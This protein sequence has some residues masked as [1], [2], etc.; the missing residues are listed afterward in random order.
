MDMALKHFYDEV[1]SSFMMCENLNSEKLTDMTL[2]S[3]FCNCFLCPFLRLN[4]GA[5]VE[6]RWSE[7]MGFFQTLLQNKNKRNIL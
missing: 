6:H 1:K 2:V 7:A 4:G 3:D 5:I